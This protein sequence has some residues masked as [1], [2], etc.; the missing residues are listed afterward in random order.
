MGRVRPAVVSRLDMRSSSPAGSA[1]RD[2]EESLRRSARNPPTGSWSRQGFHTLVTIPPLPSPTVCSGPGS[3]FMTVTGIAGLLRGLGI[4]LP[5]LTLCVAPASAQY[6]GGR[7]QTCLRL[8][9]Q[10][11]TID[12]GVAVD[13]AR[14][15]QI[16]RY[17][18]SSAKQQA[19]LDR[20][21]QQSQ[22]LGCQG[23]G[24][25]ALFSG[26]SPQC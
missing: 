1:P 8:E 15:D 23:G 11:A 10:L 26:Q 3:F 19:E 9:S 14:A 7:S 24:F 5:I 2:G 6:P 20:L 17:E 25:F 12:R 18:D 22:R 16:K 13:P 21:G 4:G